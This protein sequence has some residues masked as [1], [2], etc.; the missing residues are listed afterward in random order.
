MEKKRKKF[1]LNRH[2][3]PS[4]P[5]AICT[6]APL[7]FQLVRIVIIVVRGDLYPAV[8]AERNKRSG[9]KGERISSRGKLFSNSKGN[10]T[11]RYN[12]R[13]LVSLFPMNIC[14]IM[15][16]GGGRSTAAFMT[17]L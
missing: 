8:S 12:G 16:G 17:S 7:I 5:A 4:F 6:L 13:Q 11:N 15:G 10:A 9:G 1:R 14:L 3:R 2:P